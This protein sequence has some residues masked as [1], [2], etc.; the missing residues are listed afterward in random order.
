MSVESLRVPPHSI[1]AEQS[2][3][4]AVLLDN[5]VMDRVETLNGEDFYNEGHRLIFEAARSLWI[6]GQT[7]DAVTL[8]ERLRES[9]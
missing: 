7:F 2:I 6:A 4:G 9:G 3:I 5:R 8:C 1:E